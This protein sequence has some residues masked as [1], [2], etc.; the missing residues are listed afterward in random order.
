M[1]ILDHIDLLQIDSNTELFAK[2]GLHMNDKGNEL[3]AKKIASTIKYIHQ[4]KITEPICMTWKED[5][6][7]KITGKP[8]RH[9]KKKETVHVKKGERWIPRKALF[10][11][12]TD[13]RIEIKTQLQP[14]HHEYLWMGDCKIK[15]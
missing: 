10:S 1:K 3:A 4:E 15:T 6:V 12:A 2:H 8:P 14:C 9:M 5:H 13:V 11:K 7:K